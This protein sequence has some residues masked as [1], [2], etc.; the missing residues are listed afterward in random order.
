MANRQKLDIIDVDETKEDYQVVY[1]DL[2][3]KDIMLRRKIQKRFRQTN[4]IRKF[5]IF[6]ETQCDPE[7]DYYDKSGRAAT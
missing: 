6:C 1:C 2:Q 7:C 5:Q 4:Q 3:K